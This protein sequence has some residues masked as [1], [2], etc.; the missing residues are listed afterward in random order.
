[1]SR[2][3]VGDF[4]VLGENQDLLL[5]RGNLLAQ[6]S[7]P[8]ELAAFRGRIGPISEPLR[9]VVADL[10]EPGEKRQ[11]NTAALDPLHLRRLQPFSEISHRLLIQRRLAAG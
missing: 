1:M 8:V 6:L 9:R 5:A 11:N 4:A 3:R 2:Q 10:F 7:Q